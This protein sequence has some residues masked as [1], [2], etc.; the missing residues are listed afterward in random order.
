ML[1]NVEHSSAVI[2]LVVS[3]RGEVHKVEVE[4][5]DLRTAIDKVFHT[6]EVTLRRSKERTQDRRHTRQG[7]EDGFSNEGGE[8]DDEEF[9][10]AI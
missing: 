8:V 9:D 6:M 3:T 7:R 5:S 1:V 2:E 4:D 10:E